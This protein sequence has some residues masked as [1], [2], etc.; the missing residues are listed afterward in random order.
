MRTT[1]ATSTLSFLLASSLFAFHTTGLADDEK[2]ANAHLGTWRQVALV[3]DGKDTPVGSSTLLTTTPDGWT[4][5]I[6]GKFFSKGT[7]K[8]DPKS[9]T[10]SD[11][12]YAEGFL[13]G[14][15]LRQISK[16]EGDVLIAC[17]GAERPTQFKS[18]AGSGHTLSIWIRVK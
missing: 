6:D 16:I 13:A 15:T 18:K 14:A 12:T 3:V 7:T 10:Q 4:M 2:P 5:T 1:I 11:V 8:V 9:P 17:I